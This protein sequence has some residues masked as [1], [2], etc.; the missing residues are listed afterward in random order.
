MSNY[1]LHYWYGIPGR[2]EFVRLAF[3]YTNTPYKNST[4][5]TTLLPTVKNP[6]VGA[7]HFAPPCLELPC[8]RYISQTAAILSY[9]APKLGLDGTS[10]IQ[11]SE[12]DKAIVRAQV[13]QLVMTALDLNNEVHDVHHPISP[14]AYYEEQKEEAAKRAVSFRADRMT[15]YL[16]HFQSVLLSNAAN[17]EGSGPYLVGTKTTIADLVLFQ[18]IKGLYFAFPRRTKALKASGEYD[19]VFKLHERVAAE[20][21]IAEYL[22][23]D[24]AQAFSNHGIFRHYPELDGEK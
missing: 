17:K 24:R 1:I 18:M 14:G 10:D 5:N 15:K 20:P 2:G 13:L 21:R 22:K 19:L 12:D 7:P 23:S 4:D 16:G 9:L 3:E 11:G 8:G 6:K